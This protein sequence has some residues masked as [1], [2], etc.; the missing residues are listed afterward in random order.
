MSVDG[1][2]VSPSEKILAFNSQSG[3]DYKYT[4]TLNGVTGNGVLVFS[5]AAGKIS[6]MVGNTNV[7]TSMLVNGITIDNVAPII[8][9]DGSVTTT[10]G[11][12]I[13]SKDTVTI[14]L[15]ITEAV[16]ME[17]SVFAKEDIN[18]RI[19][20]LHDSNITSVLTYVGKTGN[21]YKYTLTI[22]GITKEGQMTIE[23]P[24]SKIE[25][26]AT[27]KNQATLLS[28]INVIVDNT[29]PKVLSVVLSLDSYNNSSK[30][31][32]SSLPIENQDWTNQTVY[33]VV[34]AEDE[35]SGIKI[36]EHSIDDAVTYTQ[37]AGANETWENEMNK[38]VCYRVIDNAGNISNVVKVVIKID[39][40]NPK[41][42]GL[43]MKEN[44]IPYVYEAGNPATSAIFIK[45]ESTYDLGTFQ[46]GIL[47]TEY[48][49]TYLKDGSTE[50]LNGNVGKLL[51]DSGNYKIDLVTT[52]RAGNQ[53]TN[54]FNAEVRRYFENMV[55]VKNIHDEGSGV[56]KVTITAIDSSGNEVVNLPI[57]NPGAAINERIKLTEG[58]FTINVKIEDGVGLTETLTGQVTNN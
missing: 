51:K 44:N 32:P 9:L 22:T 54:S 24:E 20:G 27:N 8:D 1:I 45:P 7:S 19:N 3:N 28:G 26:F 53:A 16:G 57:D 49:I 11:E 29:A 17:P 30:L 34:N 42:A 50:T 58:T 14:P 10:K 41:P 33:A 21:D 48:T 12:Y 43:E 37:M 2:Q 40:T 31:Y 46:S 5:V 47:K 56:K 39:R 25:D 55:K 38:T 6:D 18:V 35:S 23:I 52:D 4:L 15:K 36:Y 13:N